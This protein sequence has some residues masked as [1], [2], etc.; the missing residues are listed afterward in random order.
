MAKSGKK[1]KKK[2]PA[3]IIVSENNISNLL[4]DMVV[5]ESENL[6]N[7]NLTLNLTNPSVPTLEIVKIVSERLPWFE[8]EKKEFV[9]LEIQSTLQDNSMDTVKNDK[10]DNKIFQ[11]EFPSS[12]IHKILRNGSSNRTVNLLL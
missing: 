11:N 10:Q 1:K 8:D 4:D 3:K 7:I 5:V 12:S 2:Q 6:V 9:Q